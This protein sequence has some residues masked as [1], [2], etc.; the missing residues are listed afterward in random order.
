M[1]VSVMKLYFDGSCKPNPGGIARY[2]FIVTLD[3]GRPVFSGDD[4]LG[5]GAG[6]TN[7]RAEWYALGHALRAVVDADMKL[8]SLEIYGDSQLVINQLTGKWRV[9]DKH[10]A[11]VRSRCMELI[12]TIGVAWNATWVSRDNNTVA[13]R[14]AC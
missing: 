12:G 7:N 6:W 3:N 14:L 10:L 11:R 8:E 1:E 13:D 4:Y 5:E 9:R 2:G